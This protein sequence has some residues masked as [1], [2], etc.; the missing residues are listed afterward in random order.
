M[1]VCINPFHIRLMF[2]IPV[3]G[4]INGRP[5]N[6][7]EQYVDATSV[8]IHCLNLRSNVLRYNVVIDACEK[9]SLVKVIHE[10]HILYGHIKSAFA[11]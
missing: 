4:V 3:D 8:S 2:P 10:K 11:T 7:V 5:L 1:I 9:Y 6:A